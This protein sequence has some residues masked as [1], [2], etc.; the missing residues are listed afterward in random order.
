MT[1]VLALWAYL[2]TGIVYVQLAD[3]WLDLNNPCRPDT[4]ITDRLIIGG[5]W[6]IW[7]VYLAGQIIAAGTD[8]LVDHGNRRLTAAESDA[9]RRLQGIPGGAPSEVRHHPATTTPMNPGRPTEEDLSFRWL[10]LA[11]V[12]A[13]VAAAVIVVLAGAT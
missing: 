8:A 13:I 4:A 11:A 10:Y 2:A 12:F 7:T 1:A 6:P 3:R 5:S 9:A